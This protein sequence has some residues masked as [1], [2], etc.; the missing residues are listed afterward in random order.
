M[1]EKAIREMDDA[2]A[3]SPT[4]K[5]LSTFLLVLIT[6]GA[7]YSGFL[8]FAT[9][10]SIVAQVDVPFSVRIVQASTSKEQGERSD[11]SIEEPVTAPTPKGPVNILLLGID[12][13]G[14]D[15]GP[16]RT[17]T[18]ILL[19]I[20]PDNQTASMLSIPRDL[21]VSIPGYG[22]N[23]INT[24]HYV[25]DRD[26]YPGGGTALAKKTVWH[27]LGVPVDY[28]VRVNFTG[29]EK[30][31][32]ALGGITLDVDQAIHDEE[33]P[34][35]NYGTMIVD[36]PAGVQNMDGETALQYARSRHGNSDYD[37][38][39]RQQQVLM[40]A[41]DKAVKLD[42]SL[43]RIPELFET[44]G[45]SVKTDLTLG[46]IF[47]LAEMGQEIPR[48]DINFSTI[49]DSMTTTVVT[50]EGWMVEV[51]DWPKV[52]AIVD[53]LFPVPT[54]MADPERGL[55]RAKLVA[56]EASIILK[57]GTLREDLGQ[58]WSADLR[59]EGFSI[60]SYEQADRFDYR[61]TY[62]LYYADKPYTVQMLQQRLGVPDQHIEDRRGKASAADIIVTLGLD[63]TR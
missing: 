3:R 30:F 54:T 22:E 57:N 62:I 13:R 17:D 9:V 53:E 40:A 56:E 44:L 11:P 61:D 38:M 35:G 36:I 43:S 32:D 28:Y 46:Q 41:R 20:D 24:A 14:D 34:D 60:L 63:S 31:V 37:R 29:F 10:R 39:K 19:S 8:F 48:E 7:L 1:K 4:K 33:Y 18:M 2:G 25:G 59:A 23:R 27:V 50:P 21:W 52:R 58:S 15:S 47:W 42:F 51:P 26:G 49:D 16:W 55:E 5:F 12:Q 45:S 6:A